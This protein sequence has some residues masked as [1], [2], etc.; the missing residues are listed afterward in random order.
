MF[1]HVL[2]GGFINNHV[3]VVF[4]YYIIGCKFKQITLVTNTKSLVFL[5]YDKRLMKLSICYKLT[6]YIMPGIEFHALID[7][8]CYV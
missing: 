4:L 5:V 2:P 8:V 7:V 1:Q 6:L 3:D